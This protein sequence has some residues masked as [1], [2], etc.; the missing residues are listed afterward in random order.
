MARIQSQQNVLLF[1]N[2][3][4]TSNIIVLHHAQVKIDKT[5]SG[6]STFAGRELQ[7][8]KDLRAN[9]NRIVSTLAYRKIMN[10]N[11]QVFF[12]WLLETHCPNQ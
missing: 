11:A 9:K 4:V 1:F 3:A 5:I 12:L 2:S 8:T 6:S 7:F 10:S